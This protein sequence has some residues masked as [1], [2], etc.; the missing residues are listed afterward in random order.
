MFHGSDLEGHKN[1][2]QR[3][4]DD[5]ADDD[6]FH[7]LVHDFGAKQRGGDQHKGQAGPHPVRSGAVRSENQALQ[8]RTGN[9]SPAGQKQPG[10]SQKQEDVNKTHPDPG[11]AGVRRFAGHDGPAANLKIDPELQKDPQGRGPDHA[12]PKLGRNPRPH[13]QFAGTD[14][15]PDQNSPRPGQ[16][17]E[18]AG[19]RRQVRG[20]EWRNM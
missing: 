17:P 19:P 20:F 8:G 2:P 11:K 15:Q 3:N 10:K 13:H 12:G 18:R 4:E 1:Q 5:H 14:G 7:G 6:P 9:T 16:L